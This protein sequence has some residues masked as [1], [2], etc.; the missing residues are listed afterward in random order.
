MSDYIVVKIKIAAGRLLL[1][2]TIGQ[3]KVRPHFNVTEVVMCQRLFNLWRKDVLCDGCIKS[4]VCRNREVAQ[5]VSEQILNKIV[6]MEDNR[7]LQVRQLEYKYGI[8]FNLSCTYFEHKG[9]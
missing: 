6:D 7:S 8:S 9:V 5:T 3:S 2:T 1:A 4:D